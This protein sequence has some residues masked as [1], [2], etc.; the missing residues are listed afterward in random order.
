MLLLLHTVYQTE[1]ELP[2][3]WRLGGLQNA[4]YFMRVD[5]W[6]CLLMCLRFTNS[7]VNQKTRCAKMKGQLVLSSS[8]VQE[9]L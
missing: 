5:N 1:D 8:N 2:F 9:L 3:G 6:M 4:C 7:S